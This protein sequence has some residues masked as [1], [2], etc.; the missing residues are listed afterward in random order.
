MRNDVRGESTSVAR[1]VGWCAKGSVRVCVYPS[2]SSASSSERSR[3][4]LGSGL[5]EG[6]LRSGGVNDAARL[7][8]RRERCDRDRSLLLLFRHSS[9]S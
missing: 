1:R 4:T 8:L 7:W 6:S 2:R 5:L 3:F 9:S